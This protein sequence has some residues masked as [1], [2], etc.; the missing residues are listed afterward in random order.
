MGVP[1][2]H[3][4]NLTESILPSAHISDPRRDREMEY[5]RIAIQFAADFKR[6]EGKVL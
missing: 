5:G 2:F 6:I 3:L 4:D 1:D